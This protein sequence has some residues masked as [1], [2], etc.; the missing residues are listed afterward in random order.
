MVNFISL[1]ASTPAPP[2]NL[3]APDV[4]TYDLRLLFVFVGC[5][6]CVFT[7]GLFIY[8]LTALRGVLR[9]KRYKV[10]PYIVSI[11]G[12]ALMTDTFWGYLGFQVWK[13]RD[14]PAA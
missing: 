3:P 8:V 7:T 4:T 12:L 5:L 9:S 1:L 14:A 2:P 6:L 11:G 13:F 10:L